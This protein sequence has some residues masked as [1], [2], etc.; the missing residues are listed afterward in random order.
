MDGIIQPIEYRGKV[1]KKRLGLQLSLIIFLT[2]MLVNPIGF[3]D[4]QAE[5][6][7]TWWDDTLPYRVP[8]TVKGDGVASINLNFSQLFNNLGIKDALLDLRSIR[9]VPYQGGLPGSPVPYEETYSTPFIDTSTLNIDLSK[10]E[11][12]WFGE[13]DTTLAIDKARYTQETGAIHAQ[14]A[15]TSMSNAKTGF[16]YHFNGHGQTDWSE[17]EI[18]LYDVWPQVNASAIDQ[19]PDLFHFELGGLANCL[20]REFNG[21]ALA[22]DTWNSVSISLKPFGNCEAPDLK[23]IEFLRFFTK[24]KREWENNGYYE[25][26]DKVQLWLD[27]F[28]LVN[29]DGDGEIRWNAKE[30]VDLYYIYFDT[31]NHEGHPPPDLISTAEPNLTASHGMPQAG[32]YFHQITNAST[33]SLDI[34]HAPP[35]EKILQTNEAPSAA[36]PLLIHAARGEF[37]PIQLVVRSP[38][39]QNL[40]VSCS[41]LV[42]SNG[43]NSINSDHIQLFRV[44]YVEITKI[45]DYYGR[46]TLWP[47]PLYPITLGH[48]INFPAGVNQPLW[49]RIQVPANTVPGYYTGTITI[50]PASVPISVE[51]WNFILPQTLQLE[52][53]FGF[54]W[55]SVMAS[56]GGTMSGT[57]HPCQAQL[58]NAIHQTFADYRLT[59]S[60]PNDYNPPGDILLYSLTAYEIKKAQAQ[61]TQQGINVWWQFSPTDHPPLPNPAVI[62]RP[63]VDARIL[64]WLAWLDRIDGFYYPQSAD[65]DA[66]P[67]VTPFSNGLSNGDGYLFYTPKDETIGFNPCHPASNRLVPS[68]R[69]ELLREGLEDYAY[70]WLLN[71]GK[72]A[73]NQSNQADQLAM[74][75]ID[76]RT[77]YNRIPT[78]MD[79]IRAEIANHLQENYNDI[80]L[81]LP[82]ILQ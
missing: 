38:T 49:F 3:I 33:G 54:D 76:S 75:I 52:S 24:V 39:A 5:L 73:I 53:K 36:K 12:Y 43:K 21:P 28:R 81:Y 30:D 46:T 13:E 44:D 18:L 60:A 19:T 51:V 14:I 50:G 56:Y 34:W 70:L 40:P 45:S 6:S 7:D 4:V 61:Q 59:P 79:T 74:T 32:G 47:D 10:P 20:I 71:Q 67:W 25:P 64:P 41:T 58:E 11:P 77:A 1:M 27:N 48:E 62:D 16:K 15:I 37:E 66:T 35:V 69:L 78:L 9:V 42:H 80:H 72:P 8:V 22:M 82:L 57:P 2:I 55:Q 23:D 65:W 17:Y 68:I 26:G 31:L 63:G 29:Q